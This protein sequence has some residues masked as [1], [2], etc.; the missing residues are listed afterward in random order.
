MNLFLVNFRAVVLVDNRGTVLWGAFPIAYALIVSA[1]YLPACLML[2]ALS[3][4][5]T[6]KSARGI[7][8][9]AGVG[10]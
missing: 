5:S 7:F 10:P 2:A 3:S 1:L 4:A 8:A 6:S 9:R